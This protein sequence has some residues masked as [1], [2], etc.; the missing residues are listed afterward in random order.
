MLIS[1]DNLSTFG[2]YCHGVKYGTHAQFDL[3]IS[4]PVSITI[5]QC[6]HILDEYIF[7]A[8]II[9]VKP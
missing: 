7:L 5:L 1:V 6:H 9:S 4:D 3:M 2:S 8:G